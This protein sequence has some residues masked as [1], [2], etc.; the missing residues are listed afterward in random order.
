VYARTGYYTFE[1]LHL[2]HHSKKEIVVLKLDFEKTFDKLEHKMIMEVM[3]HKG[4]GEKWRSWIESILNS[5]T[6]A[7]LL[8]GVPTKAFHYK[9]GVRQGDPLSLLLFILAVDLLQ[10]IINRVTQ[11]CHL[12][13]PIPTPTLDFPII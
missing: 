2:C 3:T 7:V 9:R 6:S 5:G 12:R 10:S 11:L 4:F 13:L 8:N 1:Y